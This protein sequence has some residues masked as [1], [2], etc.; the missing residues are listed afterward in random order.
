MTLHDHPGMSF[1][2]MKTWPPTWVHCRSYPVRKQNGEIGT[3]T[4]V[5]FYED[6]PRRL[7]LNIDFDGERYMG[8]LAFND[9]AFCKQPY[10]ILQSQ[11]GQSIKQIGD[12]DL[13]H[14]L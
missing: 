6:I 9:A 1:G 12:L 4:R 7:F 10:P 5:L 3:L 14:T 8:A 13:S 2:G 11:L